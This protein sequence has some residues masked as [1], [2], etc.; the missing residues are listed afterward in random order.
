MHC[1]RKAHRY[2]QPG[3]AALLQE[4]RFARP[5]QQNAYPGSGRH[6]RRGLIAG[7]GIIAS[8]LFAVAISAKLH[9]AG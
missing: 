9:Q 4:S 1:I 2:P 3:R 8:W 6:T 5:P 7:V